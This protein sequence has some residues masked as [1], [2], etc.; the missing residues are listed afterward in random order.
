VKPESTYITFGLLQDLRGRG[1]GFGHEMAE[2]GKTVRGDPVGITGL[3]SRE[4]RLVT[5]RVLVACPACGKRQR[6][7]KRTDPVEVGCTCGAQFSCRDGVVQSSVVRAENL[8]R[9]KGSGEP[10]KWGEAHNWSWSQDDWVKLLASLR[11]SRF[12]PM[13]EDQVGQVLESLKKSRVRD[14]RR[15]TT[16]SAGVDNQT[17]PTDTGD[18]VECSCGRP[19]CTDV[20]PGHYWCSWC[21]KDCGP[22]S[23]TGPARPASTKSR[24]AAVTTESTSRTSAGRCPK[25]GFTYKWDGS[26]CGHCGYGRN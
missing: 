3:V 13:D 4:P 15:V 20:M 1:W 14:R 2:D 24:R 7:S 16:G 26:S 12:W 8:N 21:G 23:G 5:E 6:V 10:E 17:P 11:Q 22:I 18:G 9:W 19:T 25:C